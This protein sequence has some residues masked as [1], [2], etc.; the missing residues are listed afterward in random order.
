MN[1]KPLLQRVLLLLITAALLLPAT[2]LVLG[3][4]SRVLSLMGDAAASVVLDRLALAAVV[5]WVL[6]LLFLILVQAVHLVLPP[7]PPNDSQGP[8]EE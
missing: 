6:T 1:W 8:P 4:L 3:G 7:G 2:T 5:L